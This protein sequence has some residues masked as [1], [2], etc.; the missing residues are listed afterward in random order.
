M[1][2]RASRGGPY[3]S[4]RVDAS[5]YSGNTMV[6]GLSLGFRLALPAVAVTLGEDP[7][8]SYAADET[9]VRKGKKE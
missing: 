4:T 2:R 7:R 6:M 8:V 3:A 5:R 1:P 9:S